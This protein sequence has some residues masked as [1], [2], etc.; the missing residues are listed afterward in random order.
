MTD[1]KKLLKPDSMHRKYN[2]KE[3]YPDNIL[4]IGP[5]YHKNK[6]YLITVIHNHKMHNIH[7]GLQPYE[8]Y[9]DKIGNYRYDDHFDEKRRKR[10]LARSSLIA[11]KNGKYTINDPLSP[12]YY[13]IR[14]LW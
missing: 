4:G 11:D 10:Y 12:N 2:A 7:F 6:K 13:S 9:Y 8:H 14:L 3:I 5:S 1:W